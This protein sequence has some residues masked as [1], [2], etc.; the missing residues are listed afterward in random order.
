[1]TEQRI[2][3]QRQ[4]Q[5]SLLGLKYPLWVFQVDDPRWPRRLASLLP[6]SHPAK[7]TG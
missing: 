6:E 3:N 1:M 7:V 2:R 5:L 4:Q